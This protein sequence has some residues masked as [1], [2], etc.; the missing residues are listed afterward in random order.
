MKKQILSIAIVFL[1]IVATA[2]NQEY[3][4][5]MGETLSQYKNC[6]NVEDFQ[7]LANKF[8]MIANAE[9]TE[10]LPFYYHAHCYI[11]MSFMEPSDPKKKDDYLDVAEKSIEKILGLAPN[12]PE[13]YTLQGFFYTARLV[14]NPMERGQKYS[15]LSSQSLGKA[16]GMEPGNPRARVL[17]LQNEMG[18]AQFFGKDPSE[19]CGQSKEL[20]AKCDE[21][22]I[23]S[24]IY[25]NWGKDQ[26][27]GIVKGCAETK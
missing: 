4:K 1:T 12:E 21:Y 7:A 20:L 23:K 2:R 11:L 24:P 14:V 9:K 27:E 26:A 13:A 18:T 6:K 15:M 5:V 10:W 22:K 16:L 3:E 25:P 8:S 17:K 19:Y